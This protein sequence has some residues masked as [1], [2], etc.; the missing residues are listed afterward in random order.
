MRPSTKPRCTSKYFHLPSS[1]YPGD[2]ISPS[3]TFAEFIFE[4]PSSSLGPCCILPVNNFCKVL[5]WDDMNLQWKTCNHL[6]NTLFDGTSISVTRQYGLLILVH[7]LDHFL[8][9]VSPPLPRWKFCPLLFLPF[10]L[11]LFPFHRAPSTQST[12]HQPN[13][14]TSYP[15]LATPRHLYPTSVHMRYLQHSQNTPLLF[16]IQATSTTTSDSTNESNIS[17]HLRHQNSAISKYSGT[18]T[19]PLHT[20]L[21]LAYVFH[22][23]PPCMVSYRTGRSTRTCPIRYISKISPPAKADPS[24]PLIGQ[25]SPPQTPNLLIPPNPPYPTISHRSASNSPFSLSQ[26]LLDHVERLT[27]S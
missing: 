20:V 7:V 19:P 25:Y 3:L 12:R 15:P 26:D 11:Y 14:S 18:L 2:I 17:L 9:H 8:T 4:P 24:S 21:P 13:P 6:S 16:S 23:S 1:K 5:S 22:C 10:R 27:A